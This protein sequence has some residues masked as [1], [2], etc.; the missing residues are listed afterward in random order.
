[1]GV[2]RKEIFVAV[3][4]FM[5]I[6]GF[7]F[8]FAHAQDASPQPGQPSASEKKQVSDVPAF[9]ASRPKGPLPETLDPS[10]FA[11]MQTQNVYA[12]AAKVKSIIYQLPC[13]CHCDKKIGHTSL[14]SCYTDRH[15]AVCALCQKEA[16]L[17]YT[18]SKKG[19]TPTQIRKEIIDGKWKDVD[20]SIYET[21]V[22]P[23]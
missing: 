2:M 1:M 23:N 8:G 4:F 18:E 15:A 10:Q 21:P 20:L 7:C 9:H 12:L 22:T 6:A 3:I 14:L 5:A 13:Y 11:D 17:A 16:V 19:K